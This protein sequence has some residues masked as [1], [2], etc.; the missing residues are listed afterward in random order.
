MPIPGRFENYIPEIR[1]LNLAIPSNNIDQLSS[2]MGSDLT[3]PATQEQIN[4]SQAWIYDP[5]KAVWERRV[6]L[7]LSYSVGGRFTATRLAR[8]IEARDP[9]A[10]G[11]HDVFTLFLGAHTHSDAHYQ[12]IRTMVDGAHEEVASPFRHTLFLGG[13]EVHRDPRILPGKIPALIRRFGLDELPQL[14]SIAAGEAN[15][16]LVGARGYT[17]KEAEGIRILTLLRDDPRLDLD[18]QV[19]QVLIGWGQAI[20]KFDPSPA[21]FGP[22]SATLGKDSPPMFRLFGDIVYWERSSPKAA[23]ALVTASI[24]RRLRGIGAR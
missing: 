4:R 24:N 8:H 5:R 14:L 7:L 3:K 17:A 1:Q 16:V 22:L 11:F 9:S 21:F 6:A 18:E 12:K 20:D 23:V 13:R 2:L 15:L 10:S 19:K